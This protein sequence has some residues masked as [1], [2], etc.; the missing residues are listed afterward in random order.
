M[1]NREKERRRGVKWKEGRWR[2]GRDGN[3]DEQE[4]MIERR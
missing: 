4:V 2:E 3:E 1:G